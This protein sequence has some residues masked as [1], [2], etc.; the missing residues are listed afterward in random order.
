M[1]NL[2]LEVKNILQNNMFNCKVIR[3]TI[4]NFLKNLVRI[5]ILF[6]K[7]IASE[8]LTLIKKR[9]IML[10]CQNNSFKSAKNG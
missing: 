1:P 8:K 3:E 5:Y 9:K 2:T 6:T 10:N 4:A 7:K